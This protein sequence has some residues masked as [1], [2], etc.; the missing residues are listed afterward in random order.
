M[1]E[2]RGLRV[3]AGAG[4]RRQD[5]PPPSLL[6]AGRQHTCRQQG[7]AERGGRRPTTALQRDS[8]DRDWKDV[9]RRTSPPRQGQTDAAGVTSAQL[10]SEGGREWLRCTVTQLWSG[11]ALW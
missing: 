11:G 5:A 2:S 3:D 10:S 4:A 7:T 8:K 6:S 9:D 1:R